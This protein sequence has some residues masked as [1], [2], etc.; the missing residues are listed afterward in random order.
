MTTKLSP[1]GTWWMRGYEAF[2]AGEPR[3]D[4]NEI[5]EQYLSDWLEG[6]DQAQKDGQVARGRQP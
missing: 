2:E 5:P 6:W 1:E 4:K 3:E